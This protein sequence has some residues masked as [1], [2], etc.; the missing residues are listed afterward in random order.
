MRPPPGVAD[1]PLEEKIR[2]RKKIVQNLVGAGISK[3]DALQIAIFLRKGN[4]LE[5]IK[6]SN[7]YFKK[8][9]EDLPFTLECIGGKLFVLIKGAKL[10]NGESFSKRGSFKK[11][12]RAVNVETGEVVAHTVINVTKLAMKKT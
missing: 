9:I 4:S 3:E 6:A 11:V 10:I 8:N 12:T 2:E 5:E 1:F 7:A